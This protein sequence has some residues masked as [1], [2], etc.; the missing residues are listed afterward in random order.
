MPFSTI[1]IHNRIYLLLLNYK[2]PSIK[3]PPEKEAE[4]GA[5]VVTLS[6]VTDGRLVSRHS[7]RRAVSVTHPGPFDVSH[8]R[9]ISAMSM[10]R[11]RS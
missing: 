4:A 7:V 6:C 5:T 2:N 11:N 9:V 8:L 1:F 3:T 10:I